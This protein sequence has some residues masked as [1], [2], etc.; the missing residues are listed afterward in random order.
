MSPGHFFLLPEIQKTRAKPSLLYFARAM[1]ADP[2][3]SPVTGEYST[4]ELRP[5]FDESFEYNSLSTKKKCRISKMYM[6]IH[7]IV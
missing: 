4:V 6:I 2:T 3:T 5:Q 7:K 1:G